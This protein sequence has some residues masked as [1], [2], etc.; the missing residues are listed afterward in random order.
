[1]IKKE[2]PIIAQ[3]DTHEEEEDD[4][5]KLGLGDFVFYSL[6]IAKAATQL[7]I[8][9]II[10]CYLS[11]IMGLTITISLVA[12]LSRPL[13]ALPISIFIAIAIF[14]SN[15]Y[16]VVPFCNRLSLNQIFI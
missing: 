12:Y 14:F 4:G 9:T 13:P 1:M 8:T 6:L 16:T 2:D 10:A 3:I 11:I 7:N 15:E 5:P